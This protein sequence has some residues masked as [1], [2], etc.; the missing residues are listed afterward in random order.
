MK[1]K[2]LLTVP[3]WNEALVIEK[4]LHTLHVACEKFFSAYDWLIEVV[5]NGSTDDTRIIVERMVKTLDRLVL[6]TLFMQGK[7][8]AI[9]SSWLAY[10]DVCDVFLFLDADLAADISVLPQMIAPIL[11]QEA[12]LVCASRYALGARVERS[13]IRSIF[14][15][16]YRLWQKCVLHLPVQDAQCGLKA[17]SRAIV[18]QIVAEI[19]EQTWLFD[20]ELLWRAH[21]HKFVFKEIPVAWVEERTATRRSALSVWR[22]GWEFVFGVW[23]IRSR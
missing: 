14:S 12:D 2:I 10:R 22:D 13:L 7:G 1:S 5:D 8:R 6:R 3:T 16:C 9:Q 21:R 20:S 17:V 4:N 15:R 11:G 18:Q 23:R 19:Q